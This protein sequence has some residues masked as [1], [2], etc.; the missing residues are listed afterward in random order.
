MISSNKYHFAV[1][2]IIKLAANKLGGVHYD[3]SLNEK[4]KKLEELFDRLLIND[5][6]NVYANILAISDIVVKAFAPLKEII[7][8]SGGVKSRQ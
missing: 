8:N 6:P 3:K 1:K 7:E 4:E 2:D 5:L